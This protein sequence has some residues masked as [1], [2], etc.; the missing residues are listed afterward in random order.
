MLKLAAILAVGIVM[1]SGGF[2]TSQHGKDR[3]S[4]EQSVERGGSTDAFDYQVSMDDR[5]FKENASKSKITI[6]DANYD[7]PIEINFHDKTLDTVRPGDTVDVNG[8]KHVLISVTHELTD[9]ADV[10]SA[11]AGIGFSIAATL[12]FKAHEDSHGE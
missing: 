8:E 9:S 5:T 4:G 10:E 7:E 2:A 6:R 12:K 3:G 1:M 11:P